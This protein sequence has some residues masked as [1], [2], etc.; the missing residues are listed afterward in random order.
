MKIRTTPD[1]HQIDKS[2]KQLMQSNAAVQKKRWQEIEKTKMKIAKLEGEIANA[3][4]GESVFEPDQLAVSIK[5]AKEQLR[6]M[7]DEY[8]SYEASIED[9]KKNYTST[10]PNFER[11]QGWAKEFELADIDRKKMITSQLIESIEIGKQ[12][13]AIQFNIDYQQFIGEWQGEIIP[14]EINKA[15]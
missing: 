12:G 9:Q 4:I 11:F 6:Q 10:I 15:V 3:L 13:I 1:K 5:T 2:L 14:I 8:H 7:V